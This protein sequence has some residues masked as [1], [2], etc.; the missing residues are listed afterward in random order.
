[1]THAGAI[2]AAHVA[3]SRLSRP[4]YDEARASALVIDPREV[5]DIRA[6]SH[7]ARTINH[8]IGAQRAYEC[9]DTIDAR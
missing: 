3:R 5:A 7:A 6:Q 1:L 8:N 2:L 4:A 9:A